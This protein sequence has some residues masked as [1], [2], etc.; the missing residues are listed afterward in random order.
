[1]N[2]NGGTKSASDFTLH[3]NIPVVYDIENLLTKILGVKTA[4][5]TAIQLYAPASFPGNETGTTVYF[6]GPSNYVVTED[7]DSGYSTTYGEGCTGTLAIGDHVS[8]TVTND[9]IQ[10]GGGGGGGGGGAAPLACSDGSDNDSDGKADYPN[11]LGCS[12]S[13]DN[14]ESDDP[15]P[16]TSDTNGGGSTAPAGEVLGAATE[17]LPLPAGCSA[18]LTEYLKYGKKNNADEVKKLQTFLNEE[19]GTNLPVT[20]FFGQLTRTTVKKF[21][22]K[23]NADILKPWKDA[24]YKGADLDNG[25]G[26]VYKTTKRWINVMKCEALK[27]EPMP[28]L[29]PDTTGN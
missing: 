25:S 24:G 20:G 7:A 19:M 27:A 23:Y 10:Q 3:V 18:Y 11:D 1:V 14:D 16:Q 22:V 21:Q 28:E 26:Y 15:A 13:N 9:D 8:C 2:N 5:A 4:V 17:E 6:N 29:V 12:S